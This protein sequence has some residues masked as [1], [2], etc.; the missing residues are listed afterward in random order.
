MKKKYFTEEEK[1]VAR[2]IESRKYYDKIR[3]KPLT[4]EE[5]ERLKEEKIK[6]RKEYEKEY[7]KKNKEK[8]LKQ[9][10]QYFKD[11]QKIKQEKNN[12]RYKE[13]REEDPLYRLT[14]NIR[15][16][17]RC[18][19]KNNGYSKKSRS[20]EIL[21][22]SFEQFKE[23]LESQW[24]EWMNWDNHG[25]YNGDFNH[26]W[27]IDHIIPISSALSEEDIIRL[28]HYTNLQPLCSKINRVI[29]KDSIITIK[30]ENNVS[31]IYV[32]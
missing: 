14:T 11:N 8:I 24:E 13:R 28:N 21:G 12:K 3:K 4:E 17:I 29:K 5:I 25:L 1:K 31:S 16:T 7:Y 22:C 6:K 27:D 26:G 23:Y 10:K 18:S 32:K 19:L 9:S 15:R 2:K 20:Y 30:K